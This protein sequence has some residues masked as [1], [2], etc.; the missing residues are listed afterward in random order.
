M[1]IKINIDTNNP[2]DYDKLIKC[3]QLPRYTVEGNTFIT[4]QQSYDFIFGDKLD[5]SGLKVENKKAFDYQLHVVNTAL[6]RKKYA[7]FLDLWAR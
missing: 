4:D 2:D 5:L 6:R 7:A 3:K 1:T